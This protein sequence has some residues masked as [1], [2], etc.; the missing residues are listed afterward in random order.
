MFLSLITLVLLGKYLSIFKFTYGQSC[1][2]CVIF[3]QVGLPGST[4]EYFCYFVF[5][6]WENLGVP[7]STWENLGV[8]G[9]TWEYHFS[10]TPID[11]LALKPVNLLTN[12]S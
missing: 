6:S 8:L 9:S 11:D 12:V 10:I 4:W 7:G 5:L 1:F 3:F 2:Y